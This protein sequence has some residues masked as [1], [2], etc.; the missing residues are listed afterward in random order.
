MTSIFDRTGSDWLA[1]PN[2]TTRRVTGGKKNK[3]AYT[4]KG[5]YDLG[6]DGSLLIESILS[7]DETNDVITMLNMADE[8]NGGIQ[9]PTFCTSSQMGGANQ[10]R[11]P[12]SPI[13]SPIGRVAS[14]CNTA[15][16]VHLINEEALRGR[17]KLNLGKR[18]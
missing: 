1:D 18:R 15:Q 8:L 12:L 3:M 13:L 7:R 17:T 6:S 9:L 10:H 2:I 16:E 5:D 11:R 4:I 14:T